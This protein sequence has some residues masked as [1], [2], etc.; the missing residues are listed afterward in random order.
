[1]KNFINKKFEMICCTLVALII[2]NLLISVQTITEAGAR[3]QN[4]ATVLI[5]VG[6]GGEDGGAVGVDGITEKNLNLSI[7]L[8]LRETLV[9]NGYNVIMTREDDVDLSDDNLNSVSERK[10]SDMYKRIEII[11]NSKAD[12]AISIHQN[13]FEQSQ[14]KGL[15]TF[16]S[17]ENSKSLAE[18]IQKI[19]VEDLQNDNNR[20]AKQVDEKFL[21]NNS[22][23]PMLIVECGFISNAEEANLLKD[24]LYQIELATCIYKG[25]DI[26]CSQ[27]LSF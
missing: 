11:N 12:I 3:I 26:Y 14:Y 16:Y 15:Q 22:K 25:I 5:D 8:I 21:L 2:F 7:S 18:L 27:Y 1:M 10:K 17:N 19:V 9:R 4:K 24:E 13:Y 6:H 23:I 20:L